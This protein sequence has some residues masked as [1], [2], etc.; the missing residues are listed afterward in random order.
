MAN[1]R[2]HKAKMKRDAHAAFRL[3]A[4]YLARVDATPLPCMVRV[5]SKVST[6]QNE[7]T[8]PSTPGYLEIDPYVIFDVSEVPRP[9]RDG[10]VLLGSTEIY[11]VGVTEPAREGFIKASVNLVAASDCPTIIATI[12]NTGTDPAY[13]G[14]LS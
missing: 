6:N 13:I 10:L 2:D 11:R 9:S 5:H 1:W 3:P 4:V 14:V 12:P 7:F 8:W